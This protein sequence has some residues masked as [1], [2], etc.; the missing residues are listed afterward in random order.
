MIEDIT[1]KNVFVL[2]NSLSLCPISPNMMRQYIKRETRESR[3]LN[4]CGVL[5]NV[6]KTMMERAHLYV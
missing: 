5:I 1:E 3:T 4:M 2:R 6:K